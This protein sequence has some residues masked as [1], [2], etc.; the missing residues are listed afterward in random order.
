MVGRGMGGT[1]RGR[2]SGMRWQV[3]ARRLRPRGYAQRGSRGGYSRVELAL[4][5]GAV[6][7]MNAYGEGGQ[8]RSE[9]EGNAFRNT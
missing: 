6:S 5:R 4:C 1:G 9:N 2:M 8:M 7:G 3:M